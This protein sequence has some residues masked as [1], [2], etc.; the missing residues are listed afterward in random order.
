MQMKVKEVLDNLFTN[1]FTFL[2]KVV[3]I[4]LYV[5]IFSQ[6]ILDSRKSVKSIYNQRPKSERSGSNE[7]FSLQ[8]RKGKPVWLR[9]AKSE[10]T[11]TVRAVFIML[12]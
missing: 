5:R 12:R 2:Y 1:F 9:V 11:V 3:V 8:K 7:S 10:V 6:L 4:D